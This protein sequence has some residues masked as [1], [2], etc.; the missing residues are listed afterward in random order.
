MNRRSHL[1][2]ALGCVLGLVFLPCASAQEAASPPGLPS[3]ESILDRYVEVTG[4]AAAYGRRTSE[5]MTGTFQIVAANLTGELRMFVEPGLQR[6]SIELPG[7][8]LIET[9]VN[10]GVAW[11]VDPIAGP[12]LLQGFEAEFT[13]TSSRP[14]A[15]AHWREQFKT[16]ETAG[17]DDVGGEPAYRVVQT[18]GGGGSFTSFYS[19]DSGLLAKI[20]LGPVEQIYEEY[21]EFDGILTPSRIVTLNSGQRII[22]DVA[23]LDANVDI[24]D[25][26]FALPE[27]VKALL[28]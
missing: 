8:G 1:R 6:T 27:A 18:L 10:D 3:A 16:V 28:K 22:I 15:P 7:V 23:S 12:R 4:G 17:I 26:R 2:S 25:E 11:A 5:A 13:I 14:G 9:G 21:S 24:P 20:A 19:V